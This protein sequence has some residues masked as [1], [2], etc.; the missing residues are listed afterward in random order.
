[1]SSDSLPV[2]RD[3]ETRGI[4][5]KE[6]VRVKPTVDP[7]DMP[8]VEQQ[9]RQLCVAL[10][11]IN[12]GGVLSRLAQKFRLALSETSL[13]VVI[14]SY[15]DTGKDIELL[16][17]V[18]NGDE[19]DLTT[20]ERVLR[21]L[22]PDSYELSRTVWG[23]EQHRSQTSRQGDDT[24]VAGVRWIGEADDRQ[25][26]QTEL[27][28]EP[29]GGTSDAAGRSPLTTVVNAM[30]GSSV[31]MV[32]QAVITPC[33]DWSRRGDSHIR[34]IKTNTKTPINKII[35]SG[36]EKLEDDT[37]NHSAQQRIEQVKNR[38]SKR[39]AVVNARA[40]AL[41]P[42]DVD[43][44]SDL[45]TIE[46]AFAYFGGDFHRVIGR[47]FE[48]APVTDDAAES[49]T[50]YNEICERT[51]S[52][53]EYQRFRTWLPFI[54]NRSR[55][56][57]ADSQ[58]IGHFLLVDGSG[59]TDAAERA[60]GTIEKQRTSLPRPPSSVLSQY[61]DEGLLLG[62]PLTQDK[63]ASSSLTL[64]PKL[65]SLHVGWIGA[66]GAGKSVGLTNAILENHAATDGP[67]III[68]PKGGSMP[69]EYLRSH[70][71]Q[72]GSL[73]DVLYFDL[74]KAVPALEILD[75]RDEVEAEVPRS[76]AVEDTVGH[77]EE[78]L[79]QLV[80]TDLYDRAVRAP[81]VISVMLTALF[82][83]NNGDDAVTYREYHEAL[84]R[85]EKG[86]PPSVTDENLQTLLSNLASNDSQRSW[87]E[88]MQG[89][90]TRAE[91]VLAQ[92]HLS[93]MFNHLSTSPDDPVFDFGD[94]LN[95]D[96]VIIF[97]V[98]E[99]HTHARRAV[100]LTLLAEVWSALKRRHRGSDDG[101]RSLVNI[102]LDEAPALA[103]TDLLD[104]LLS[105]G[106]EFDCA[107]T[108]AMQYPAQIRQTDER[109]YTELLNDVG[110]YV[111]GGVNVDEDLAE[112]LA[113]DAVDADA[114]ATR[115]SSLA[116]GEWLVD[117]PS[118]FGDRPPEPFVLQSAP[119]PAGHPAGDEGAASNDAFAEAREACL[120][121]TRTQ[122]AL[123]VKTDAAPDEPTD[124]SEGGKPDHDATSPATPTPLET[125]TRLPRC[126]RYESQRDALVCRDCEHRYDPTAAGMKDA[127]RCC[128][129]LAAVDRD[130]I[131]V[132]SAAI[133]LSPEE[134]ADTEWTDRQLL[135]AQ[136][137]HDAHQQKYDADTEY[138]I[139]S[140]SMIR[141]KEY[142]GIGD[143]AVEELIDAGLVR[144]DS[145]H[146]H[147]LY[148]VTDTGRSLLNE[149][150]REGVSFGDGEGD[151]GESSQ[152]VLL[153][154]A[155]RRHLV[156]DY[157]DNSDSAVTR[158]ETYYEIGG[159]ERLDVAGL[160]D[161]GSVIVAGEAERINNDA[162]EAAPSD[163]DKMA[164]L[165]LE[166]AIW[167]VPTQSAGHDLLQ[168]L[169]DPADDD[170]RV[171]KDYAS[172]T[173]PHQFRIDTD[174]LTAVYS[175]THLLE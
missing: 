23:L 3:D 79:K 49:V 125:T 108:L 82:D 174:G 88:I 97:D 73:D 64:P 153:V 71:E 86:S 61:H 93:L 146:P 33:S 144:Q 29:V 107:L 94:W 11:E 151:L 40:V 133:K 37:L 89:V 95:E 42:P 25:D 173:P 62:R 26:W 171:E 55:G 85:L 164:A 127:I 72:Y 138:D 126:V 124:A 154:E 54:P 131:P 58:E 52:R 118:G 78:V 152:H 46:S 116:R 28:T 17:R 4:A 77:V 84:Q 150:Y 51:V 163:Y 175:V 172:N 20:L 13:E 74:A 139:T 102:Y 114:I 90:Y 159:G 43:I 60:L 41:G 22:L 70:Y 110:T 137:V 156:S 32:Y 170:S 5:S 7:L 45:E 69:E 36:G 169:R 155:V 10:K 161:E 91:S 111:V 14:V 39:S 136:I 24:R 87:P 140:D 30:Q 21:S 44:E 134:R 147:R 128:N 115:L 145:D 27:A 162:A 105:R 38:D 65:Q 63:T 9:Q 31:P 112:R 135:F 165:D 104:E 68:D 16:Y 76:V 53:P 96:V 98:G 119:P 1:M 99:L 83:A 129:A 142:A 67:E 120:Q 121:R 167:V 103:D 148:T 8:T 132:A 35:N 81:D 130:D 113:T 48:S 66:T 157:R 80:G 117:L 19:T 101:D 123:P 57:V 2:P 160:D 59:L 149:R 47:H 158:V 92:T 100:T 75:I 109:A 141:L 15:G 168:A 12:A 6:Y 50:I 143:E 34:S 56:I 122:Y 166:E 106:R 18:V